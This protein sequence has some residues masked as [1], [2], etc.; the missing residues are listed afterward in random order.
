VIHGIASHQTSS[1]GTPSMFLA[2]PCWRTPVTVTH[3]ADNP[4]NP[5]PNFGFSGPLRPTYPLSPR[6]VVPDHIP[7]PDYAEEGSPVIS[8]RAMLRN[9]D[10]DR[11]SGIPMSENRSNGQPPRILSL[12]EQEKMR[13]VCRVGARLFAMDRT[14][15][16]VDC[17]SSG[18]DHA[19]TCS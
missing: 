18:P 8:S 15:P 1:D 9:T 3:L 11:P 14:S 12:E 4:F 2:E 6:R 17:P 7:R 5:F 13:T 16:S 10:A 19:S